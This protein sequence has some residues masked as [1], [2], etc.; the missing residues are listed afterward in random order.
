MGRRQQWVY[1]VEPAEWPADFSERLIAVQGCLR[2]VMARSG[3][4]AKVSTL[5]PS[6]DGA[7]APCRAPATFFLC[8]SPQRA[9]TCCTC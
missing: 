1:T 7:P 3:A 4:H 9:W 2:S 5:E 8:S 6:V